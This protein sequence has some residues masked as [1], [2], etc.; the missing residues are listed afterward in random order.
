MNPDMKT[1]SSKFVEEYKSSIVATL[2]MKLLEIGLKFKQIYS[3]RNMNDTK[4]VNNSNSTAP[5]P[6]LSKS[7]FLEQSQEEMM[8]EMFPF[9][10]YDDGTTDDEGQPIEPPQMG[11]RQVEE[12]ITY[13][14]FDRF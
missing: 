11:I 4:S 14:N 3:T 13:G 12:Y 5:S 2:E 8:E 10:F 6:N 1:S 9:G 7:H